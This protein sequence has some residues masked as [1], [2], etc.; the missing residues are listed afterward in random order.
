MFCKKIQL[1]KY[2]IIKRSSWK[3]LCSTLHIIKGLFFKKIR[4]RIYLNI[5]RFANEFQSFI[6]SSFMSE[7]YCCSK[8]FLLW[9]TISN[10]KS[11]KSPFTE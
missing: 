10:L 8:T 1:Y 2:S 7:T 9:K 5:Y 6:A 4:N 11:R 3:H